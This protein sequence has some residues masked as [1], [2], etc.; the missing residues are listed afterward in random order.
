MAWAFRKE[1]QDLQA[2]A[3][4]FIRMQRKDAGSLMN[5]QFQSAYGKTVTEY[6][7]FVRGLK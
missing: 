7:D 1:D 6:D 4:R 3:R 5:K 2:V